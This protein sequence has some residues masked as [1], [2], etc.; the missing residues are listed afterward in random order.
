MDFAHWRWGANGGYHHLEPFCSA[1]F[2]QWLQGSHRLLS[3]HHEASREP[4]KDTSPKHGKNAQLD[5][6]DWAKDGEQLQIHCS[7]SP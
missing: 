4:R 5:W 2:G 3:V 1:G 7:V 6:L